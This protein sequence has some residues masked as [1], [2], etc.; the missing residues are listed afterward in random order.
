M[1]GTV[2][3][4]LGALMLVGSVVGAEVMDGSQDGFWV[5]GLVGVLM[6]LE[7]ADR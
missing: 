6:L 1:K 3:I 5:T 2:L 4:V 7:G